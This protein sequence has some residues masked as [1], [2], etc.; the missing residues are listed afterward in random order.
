LTHATPGWFSRPRRLL[1]CR[2]P[3]RPGRNT[4]FPAR[5]RRGRHA[6]AGRAGV[7]EPRPAPDADPGS[8]NEIRA[9]VEKLNR[10]LEA[11]PLEARYSVD[12]ATRRVVVKIVNRESGETLRQIPSEEALRLAAVLTENTGRAPAPPGWPRDTAA[13]LRLVDE[14][15]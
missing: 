3:A 1:L 11:R 5:R 15:A 2:R 6:P 13:L 12:E 7:E 14:T 10:R 4:T 8:A 9:A